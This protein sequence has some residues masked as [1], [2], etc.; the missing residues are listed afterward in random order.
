MDKK[1]QKVLKALK[2]TSMNV[3]LMFKD[4]EIRNR[5]KASVSITEISFIIKRFYLAKNLVSI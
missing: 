2:I 3:I 5:Q 1:A 4:K